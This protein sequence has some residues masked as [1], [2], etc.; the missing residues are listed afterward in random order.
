MTRLETTAAFP[1]ENM[2][3]VKASLI[4][5]R[6]FDGDI[7]FSLAASMEVTAGFAARYEETAQYGYMPPIRRVV[8]EGSGGEKR[9]DF[10]YRGEVSGWGA[11]VNDSVQCLN[12]QSA[13]RPFDLSENIGLHINRAADGKGR[14]A[15]NG[16]LKDGFWTVETAVRENSQPELAAAY[17]FFMVNDDKCVK[18]SGAR[19]A[20]YCVSPAEEPAIKEACRVYDDILDFY[21]KALYPPLGGEER[22]LISLSRE[23]YTGGYFTPKVILSTAMPGD[24]KRLAHWLAHETA[25]SWCMGAPMDWN[26]WLNETTAEWSALLW[27]LNK[28]NKALFERKIEEARGRLVK[29]GVIKPPDGS[30]PPDVHHRGV[31]LFYLLYK[32]YG[33]KAVA[34]L[35]TIFQQLPLPKTTEKYLAAVRDHD[36]DIARDIEKA[37]ELKA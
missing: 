14:L 10:E 32:V 5:D 23:D 29:G 36:P 37:L 31:L 33:Q 24:M 19:L 25:H 11:L 7:S 13:W 18:A 26:D 16:S 8:I 17:G 15:L 6:P 20:A 30:R 28:G 27:E 9:L 2:I 21:H 1:R 12:Y 34:R 3:E 4:S 35:L 22:A